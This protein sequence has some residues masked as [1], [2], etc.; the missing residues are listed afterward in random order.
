M[1]E[2]AQEFEP[3]PWM[4]SLKKDPIPLLL[5]A[6][7]LPIRFQIFRDILDDTSS[8]DLLLLQKNLRKHQPR[9]KRLAEQNEEG[10]WPIDGSVKG[11]DK[12]QIQTLQFIKQIESLHE[13][14]ELMVTGK[15]EKVI[16][17]MREVIRF[18]AE[19]KLPL[20]FHHLTQ[21]VFLAISFKLDGN[22]IIKDLIRNMLQSQNSDGG[23]SS[24][25]GEKDSCIWSSQFFLWTLGHSASFRKNRV[26]QKGLGFLKANV[27][28]EDKSPLIPGMQAWDTLITGTSGL[29]TL[30]GGTL[31]F[32]ETL[33]ISAEPQRDR[34]V[35]KL[36]DWLM[37]TQLKTGLW[38]SIVGRDRQGDHLVTLRVLKV[39]KHFQMQRVQE[40]LNYEKQNA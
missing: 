38:P 30:T 19:N 10:L 26:L 23:W 36:L 22:P 18:L 3:L 31:R 6:A 28:L 39:L 29:A 16:L 8:D 24:L 5:K 20:R 14:L 13:L 4:V 7:P 25:P 32:L 37:E 9:R 15:Q 12:T 33:Q 27:L 40:T 34:K 17:G 35:D 1:I 21:A 11:L 2:E